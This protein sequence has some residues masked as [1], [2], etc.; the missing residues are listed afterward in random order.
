MLR[1]FLIWYVRFQHEDGYV[2]CVVDRDGV[3]DLVENDSHG[4]LIWGICEVFRNEGN[5]DFLKSMWQPVHRAAEYLRRLR[6]QRM[7][8]EFSEPERS[9]RYGLLPESASH[10]GYLAHPVHSYWDDFWGIRG[11]EAA[12]ELAKA[13][14]HH[15]ESARWQ[16]EARAF[17]ADV[18]VSIDKVIEEHQL[19]YI[20]GSVEW[21]DFDPTATSNAIAQLDFADDLPAV[22]LHQMLETYLEGFR[23]KHRG[24]IPWLNYTAYEIRIIGAFVRLGKRRGSARTA[25]RLPRGP[26]ADR[27]EPMAGNHLARPPL[28][29]PSG[30]RTP[31]LD[32][33]GIHA[34]HRRHGRKRA[35]GVGE[36]R[37]RVGTA[38]GVDRRGGRILRARVDDPLW[39]AGFPDGCPGNPLH[40]LHHRRWHDHSARRIDRHS[41]APARTTHPPRALLG[42]ASAGHR[43]ARRVGDREESSHR[44]HAVSRR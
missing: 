7:T 13:L 17:L 19:T 25:R 24:E 1:D 9:D 21:A 22:P 37:A 35:R 6:S 26:P 15:E 30:R 5:M 33:G 23:Q 8:R 44:S 34:G 29:G 16:D 36:A 28:A 43:R 14:G 4:Q 42:R 38:M 39:Q 10:E 18:L 41:A 31:H 20:P 2:P 27:V 3:D 12:A 32:R 11:L 40:P